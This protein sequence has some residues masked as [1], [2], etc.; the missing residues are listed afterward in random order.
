MSRSDPPDHLERARSAVL[1]RHGAA[2]A[3]LR[4]VRVGGGFSGAAV[5][6]GDDP[7]GSPVLALKAWPDETSAERLAH[8]HRQMA[9]ALHLPFVPAVVPNR[10]NLT[11]TVEAGRAWD[12][13]RWMPGAAD[14]HARPT[15]A[16]LAN[17]CAAIAQ[18]HRAWAPAVPAFAPCP[19]VRRRL[20][21]LARWQSLRLWPADPPSPVAPEL[22]DLLRR[23]R[24]LVARAAP[25]AGRALVP[26]VDRPFPVQPCLCDVWHDHVLF[27]GDVVT[28]L[29]DYGA[30]KDDS[31][32]VDLARLL[33]DLVG[34]D[35]ARFAA[36]LAAYRAAGG[37]PPPDGFVRALDRSGAVCGVAVWLLRLLAE[38]RGYPDPAAVA[39]RLG[40]LAD[41]LERLSP[42]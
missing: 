7:V 6:R 36:G 8:V 25:W 34:D 16:R 39:A 22:G 19:A 4:W 42:G 14:F 21:V 29:I 33:G 17:A 28:G 35:D 1:A 13:A 40:R 26:W 10:E 5:W 38:R 18:L 3:G 37:S 11:A 24:D 23:G 30:V 41:R 20:D 32:A 9:R 15:D 12:V 2:V 31:V 27:T